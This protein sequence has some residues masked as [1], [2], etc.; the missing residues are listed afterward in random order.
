[1]NL[2]GRTSPLLARLAVGALYLLTG[3]YFTIN[4][5]Q[6]QQT[7]SP[8]SAPGSDNVTAINNNANGCATLVDS[9]NAYQGPN[10]VTITT[11]LN[12]PV[13]PASGTITTTGYQISAGGSS[14]NL[15]ANGATFSNASGGPITV[16]GVAD[17]ANPFDA[18]NFRQLQAVSTGVAS[19]AAMSNIP[20][21]DPNKKFGIGI[22][23]GNFQGNS[24]LA[25]GINGRLAPSLTAKVSVGA[26]LS[27]GATSVGTGLSY[28][29]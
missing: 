20:G 1:M 4:T 9:T 21:L 23:Y 18:V 3:S 24:A 10:P 27:Y 15:N 8:C 25:V 28:A 19:I 26:G 12:P 17:G 16:T 2:M 29:W 13:G 14:F 6:A 11:T 5:A 7:F 22:G